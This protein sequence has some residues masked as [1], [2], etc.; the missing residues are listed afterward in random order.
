MTSRNFLARIAASERG[1]L[2]LVANKGGT[3]AQ[4][5]VISLERHK[6]ALM[7]H[8]CVALTGLFRIETRADG[9]RPSFER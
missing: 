4:C 7:L 6:N 2:F 9:K 3:V 5:R 1:R 8:H